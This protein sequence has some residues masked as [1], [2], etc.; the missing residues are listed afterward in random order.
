MDILFRRAQVKR[1]LSG[2]VNFKLHAKIELS[3]EERS[4]VN[5][6]YFARSTLVEVDQP[7]LMRNTIL[8]SLLSFL[9]ILPVTAWNFWREI[10]LGWAGVICVSALAAI[11]IG[12]F[13]Y[14]QLRETIYVKDLI[15]GRY[16]KCRSVCALARKEAY[17]HGIT[18][19]LRQ[20]IESAKHWDGDEKFEVL[21]LSPEE[22]KRMI[23]SGPMF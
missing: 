11:G 9:I 20:V 13:I 21:P 18:A 10:G 16:F 19:Y 1:P 2:G 6:Y 12:I 23:L 15:H 4:L 14:T 5:R 7:G 8:L 3:D 22:A 17:L